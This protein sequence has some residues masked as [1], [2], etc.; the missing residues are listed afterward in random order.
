VSKFNS[1]VK[2]QSTALIAFYGMLAEGAMADWSAIYMNTVIGETEVFSAIA[3][4]GFGVSMTVGRI[5]GDYFT[6]QLGKKK[7]MIWNAAISISGFMLVLA[8]AAPWTTIIGFFLVGLGLASVVP[9]VYSVAGNVTD[10]SPGIGIAM[11]T[12]IGY[13]GFFV[14]PPA[15]GYLAD[16]YGLR[17]GLS[18]SLLLLAVMLI[19]IL[20]QNFGKFVYCSEPAKR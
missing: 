9:I 17:V 2:D 11:V 3:F 12:T 10:I 1:V 19:L 5:M 7:L 6:Q 4:G 20:K 16:I 14:G 13:S 8:F 18:F 15:I